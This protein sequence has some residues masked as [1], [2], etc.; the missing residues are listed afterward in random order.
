MVDR[1]SHDHSLAHQY[2]VPIWRSITK[3]IPRP[4]SRSILQKRSRAVAGSSRIRYYWTNR[5]AHPLRQV[6]V[7]TDDM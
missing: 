7:R 4:I 5:V 3:A 1:K 2:P 6:G